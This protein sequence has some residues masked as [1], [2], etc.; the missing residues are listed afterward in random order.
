MNCSFLLCFS[1]EL[2]VDSKEKLCNW[3][4]GG[5]KQEFLEGL[6]ILPK[7]RDGWKVG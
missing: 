2:K 4:L 3:P 7:F 1:D 5:T 6:I